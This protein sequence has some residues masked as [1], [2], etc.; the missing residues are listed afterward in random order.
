MK[1]WLAFA[2]GFGTGWAIRSIADSPH[3]VGVKLVEVGYRVKKNVVHWF[4]V[5][6]ER[7]SDIIAEA[8]FRAN[9]TGMGKDSSDQDPLFDQFSS[10]QK[11]A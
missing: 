5:E 10:A 3:G 6:R 4:A 9:L 8:Q 2:V 7:I 11:A 1:T